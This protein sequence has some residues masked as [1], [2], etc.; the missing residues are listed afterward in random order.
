[1]TDFKTVAQADELNPGE[2]ILVQDGRMRI[3]IF[4]VDGEHYAIEDRCSHADVA[5]SDGKIDLK[6]CQITCPKHGAKFDITTGA[7]LKAPAVA[8]VMAFDVRVE[9]G[10][11]QIKRRTR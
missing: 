5:L 3:L 9:D 4:N 8:P 6:T 10:A 2:A 11:I 1:M 7:A